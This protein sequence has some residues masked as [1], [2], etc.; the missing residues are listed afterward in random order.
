MH[1]AAAAGTPV[2][3]LFGPTSPVRT[4]PYG[5]GHEVIR[6]DLTCSPCFRKECGTK[7]CMDEISVDRVFE[8]V[9]KMLDSVSS[10]E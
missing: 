1:I 2:V 10:T 4:G 7:K 9:R 3:A 6:A 8:A 5:R